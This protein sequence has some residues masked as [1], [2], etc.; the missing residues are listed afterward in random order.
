MLVHLL[1]GYTVASEY[2]VFNSVMDFFFFCLICIMKMAS[3][4]PLCEKEVRKGLLR[5]Q[6]LPEF[7]V[8]CKYFVT[9]ATECGLSHLRLWMTAKSSFLSPFKKNHMS[10]SC[11][12]VTQHLCAWMQPSC[13]TPLI[14]FYVITIITE[15]WSN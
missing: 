9:V 10:L 8:L 4:F 7:A 1:I 11:V 12:V 3:H 2:C 13:K 6:T 5:I 14:C 15:W